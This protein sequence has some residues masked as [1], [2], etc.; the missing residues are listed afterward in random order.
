MSVRIGFNRTVKRL[1]NQRVVIS[2]IHH[3]SNNTTVIEI[4]N[5]TEIDLVYLDPLIPFSSWLPLPER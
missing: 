4:K 2:V 1:E 5:G 3:I